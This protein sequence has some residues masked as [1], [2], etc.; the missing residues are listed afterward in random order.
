MK[1]GFNGENGWVLYFGAG[2]MG[3]EAIIYLMNKMSMA[4]SQTEPI[5][6][7]SFVDLSLDPMDAVGG[8]SCN[9]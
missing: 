5:I 2:T 1:L 7:I 3:T 9:D 8:T 4:T 6:D